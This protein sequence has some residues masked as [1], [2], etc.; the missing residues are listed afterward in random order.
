MFYYAEL[1]K[2]KV[3]IER[4]SKEGREKGRIEGNG[5]GKKG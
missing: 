1:G 2:G 4:G 5:R 3:G